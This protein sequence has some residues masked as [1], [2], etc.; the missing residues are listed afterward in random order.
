[1]LRVVCVQQGDYCGRG[2]EYVNTLYDMVRRNL[3][4][5]LPGVFECF[6][7]NPEGLTEGIVGRELPHAGLTGWWNKLALFKPGLWPDGDRSG[8]LRC[9]R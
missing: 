6:T 8:T 2:V 7:D 3:G 9:H 4:E 1:M 5:G